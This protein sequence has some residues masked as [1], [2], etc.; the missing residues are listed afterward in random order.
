MW[1]SVY[2]PFAG[3]RLQGKT[4]DSRCRGDSLLVVRRT[5]AAVCRV[6]NNCLG[7]DMSIA[8]HNA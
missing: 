8:A 1:I 2:C 3:V 7:A 4:M 6:G 5:K